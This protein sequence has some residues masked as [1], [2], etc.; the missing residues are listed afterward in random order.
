MHRRTAAPRWR[1]TSNGCCA[2]ATSCRSTA[3]YSP[4]T[5]SGIRRR[6]TAPSRIATASCILRGAEVE[7]DYGHLLVYGVNEDIAR[8][9]DFSN[10]RLERARAV[11]RGGA[12]G[13]IALPC[14]PGRPT[15]GLC[16]H[17]DK[18]P[19]IE[20]V[21]AVEALNGGSRRGGKRAG[22][23]AD[24]SSW[25]SQLRRQRLAPGELH[26]HLCHRVRPRHRRRR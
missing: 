25:L 4:S 17:Y 15:V 2:S 22:P 23:R 8:Y 13:G 18:K 20:G 14:H 7:T 12:P 24:R 6:S 11:A 19:P 10:I 26:R 9:F 5:G 3:S 21:V 16:E 1:A